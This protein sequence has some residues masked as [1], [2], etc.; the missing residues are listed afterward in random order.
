MS[1]MDI[2]CCCYL[3]QLVDFN[4]CTS[5]VIEIP[6]QCCHCPHGNEDKQKIM[7]Y[8]IIPIFIQF[9]PIRSRINQ[10]LS[11]DSNLLSSNRSIW[12]TC[13]NSFSN[14]IHPLPVK[15]N[16]IILLDCSAEICWLAKFLIMKCVAMHR[17]LLEFFSSL[18]NSQ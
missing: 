18:K 8:S 9:R 16:L 4:I 7:K 3:K 2:F 14:F 11:H 1:A 5:W 13:T 12:H 10:S 15:W 6:I 17:S